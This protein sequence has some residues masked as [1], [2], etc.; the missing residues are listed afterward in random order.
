MACDGYAIKNTV[1]RFFETIFRFFRKSKWWQHLSFDV[2]E[3]CSFVA[4]VG[5]D[6]DYA[7]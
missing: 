1:S 2:H 6:L 7:A 3:L 4:H 5:F